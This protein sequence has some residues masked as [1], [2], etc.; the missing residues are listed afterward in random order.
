M[1]FD[2]KDKYPMLTDKQINDYYNKIKDAPICTYR[3]TDLNDACVKFIIESVKDWT[4]GIVID[5]AAG[6]G[7]LAELLSQYCNVT[8]MDIVIPSKPSSC[9]K[10]IQG[11]LRNIPFQDNSFDVVICTHA[12]EHIREYKVAIKELKR[13]SRKYIIII[14]PCQREYRYTVD[15]HMNFCPYLYRFI[16][17]VGEPEARYFKLKGDW[18]CVI[19]V[20]G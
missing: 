16:E 19:D 4:G 12:I 14:T 2:F 6:R 3:Q 8:A 7:Y 20:R 10:W 17:L 11:D 5:V 1:L 9:V 15:L 18:V 13:I